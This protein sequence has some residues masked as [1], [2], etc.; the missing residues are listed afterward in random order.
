MK[1]QLTVYTQAVENPWREGLPGVCEFGLTS[2]GLLN[3][4]NG[5]IDFSALRHE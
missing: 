1:Y 3:L 4:R 5:S 2:A